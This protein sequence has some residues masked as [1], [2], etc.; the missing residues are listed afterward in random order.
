VIPT[1]YPGVESVAG[2]QT[3]TLRSGEQRENVDIRLRKSPS[4]CLEGV[5]PGIGANAF[6]FSIVEASP[7]SGSSGSG[8]TY[9]GEPGGKMGPDGKLRICDLHPDSYRITIRSESEPG[10]FKPPEFFS[11]AIHTISDR[12]GGITIAPLPKIQMKGEI[13]WAQSPLEGFTFPAN[14]V[15]Q[16]QAFTRTSNSEG[17]FPRPRAM[18][19]FDLDNLFLDEYRL[20]LP[21]NPLGGNVYVKAVTYGDSDL[22][23]EPFRP[24]TQPGDQRLRVILA[25]DG[26]KV[27]AT[28]VDRE[29]KTLSDQHVIILPKAIRSEAELADIAVSGQTDQNGEWTS[30]AMAPGRYYVLASRTPFDRTPE[31]IARL[32]AGR[33][34]G[35]EVE[36]APGATADGVVSIQ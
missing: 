1:Y 4:Y 33:D 7:H 6:R 12:D 17:S 27:K 14:W 30:T 23:R 10:I 26:G 22:L 15:P 19:P 18:G 25:H 34:K 11:T 16:L 32:W 35:K 3:I 8:G 36:V 31:T 2:A 24:G 29:G 20:T 5:V 28:V 9:M 21:P 13:V